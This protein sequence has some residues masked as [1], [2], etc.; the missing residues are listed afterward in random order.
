M[1]AFMAFNI[2]VDDENAREGGT[3]SR[4]H[5]ESPSITG[6][7]NHSEEERYIAIMKEHQFGN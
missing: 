5:C 7:L 4:H 2:L 3:T 6:R 1:L